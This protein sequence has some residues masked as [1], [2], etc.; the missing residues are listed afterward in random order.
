M[1]KSRIAPTPSGFL[2]VGNALNFLLTSAIVQEGGGELRLRI[3]DLDAPRIRPE[4]LEDIFETLSWLDIRYQQGPTDAADHVAKFRQELRLPV[5]HSLLN[6]LAVSGHL[7]A[8]N[9]SRK[10]LLAV[11]PDGQ[12]SG[13]CRFK[14]I[15]LDTPD[16]SWRLITPQNKAIQF[17]DTLMGDVSINL[18]QQARDMI[19]RRRD[20]LPAY[21]MASLADDMGYGINTIVRGED[22]LLSTA[23]QL[24]LAE[25]LELDPFLQTTFYHHPLLVDGSGQKISKSAGSASIRAMRRAGVPWDAF[26]EQF[27]N[28]R[29]QLAI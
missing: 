16:V 24:Y 29:N 9:C 20:G 17:G 25:L 15:P 10:A 19:V 11:S 1:I 23:V 4:Y 13:T 21:H 27:S 5:Y 18:Y 3:D 2:H 8:C 26:L 28:W 22:L 14:N 7:F 12:Y 6:Q